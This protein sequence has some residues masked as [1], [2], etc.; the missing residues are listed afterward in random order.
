MHNHRKSRRL[1]ADAAAF[2]DLLD[3]LD[4]I[5]GSDREE[6]DDDTS[7]VRM[8]MGGRN[9]MAAESSSIHRRSEEEEDDE[10]DEEDGFDSVGALPSAA[11]RMSVVGSGRASLTVAQGGRRDTL[12]LI[13]GDGTSRASTGALD[14]RRDTMD[15][16]GILAEEED[17]ESS[18]DESVDTSLEH[19]KSTGR[20]NNPNT[21]S[22][23]D[24]L[25]RFEAQFDGNGHAVTNTHI[26]KIGCFQTGNHAT[27]RP[28]REMPDHITC[29]MGERRLC[30]VLGDINIARACAQSRLGPAVERSMR[31]GR[32][33]QPVTQ[34]CIDTVIDIGHASTSSGL[35][36][37]SP[38]F[39]SPAFC[40]IAYSMKFL[41]SSLN[42]SMDRSVIRMGN[43]TPSR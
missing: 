28:A 9:G 38:A 4:S 13:G 26:F 33:D 22:A 2:D 34:G 41:S 6:D 1:T 10:E 39:C 40:S 24:L 43:N 32:D 36:S 31:Q 18:A 16:L 12:D 37:C 19:R 14:H 30:D 3:D 21:H 8:T 23:D 25:D 5:G 17:A 20:S 35:P 11:S 27:V 7:N 29:T 15:M 42:V